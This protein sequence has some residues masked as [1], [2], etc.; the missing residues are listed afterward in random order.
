MQTLKMYR[1]RGQLEYFIFSLG[2]VFGAKHHSGGDGESEV[3]PLFVQ[4]KHMKV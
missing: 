4:N 2:Y 1:K 3:V